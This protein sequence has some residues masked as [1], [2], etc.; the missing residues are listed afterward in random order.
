M[1][2]KLMLVVL[3][4]FESQSTNV[5]FDIALPSK[6]WSQNVH[7]GSLP[8]ISCLMITTIITKLNE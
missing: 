6:D 4:F 1:T 5:I 8:L 7:E 3:K 2:Y